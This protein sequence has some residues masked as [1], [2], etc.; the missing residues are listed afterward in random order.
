MK[1]IIYAPSYDERIGGS[2]VLH[3]LCQILANLGYEA[4]I[5]PADKV[6]R[7]SESFF[8]WLEYLFKS[9]LKYVFGYRFRAGESYSLRIAR[10]SEIFDSVVIYPEVISGNPLGANKV[11]RWFLHS[12]SYHTGQFIFGENELHFYFQEVFKKKFQNAED[13]GQLFLINVFSNIFNK[14]NFGRRKGSCYILRKG[15]SRVDI[16]DFKDAIVID[17][18]PMEQISEIFNHVEFC[19]SYDMHTFLSV[20]AVMCG[21]KSIVMPLDGVEKNEWQPVEALRYGLAYGMNDIANADATSDKL[22]E[23]ILKK[24]GE[25]ENSVINFANKCR[26]FFF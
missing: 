16:K 10:E 11:V 19:I 13:G 7:N 4:S 8:K 5:W 1:F 17:D 22:I 23:S 24:E 3:E 9:I 2:I 14:R 18:L 6:N 20:Y 25:N 15:R 26:K 21:C 12:P